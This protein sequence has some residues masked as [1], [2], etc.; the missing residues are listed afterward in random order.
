MSR[1]SCNTIRDILPLYVDEVVSA[2][3]REIVEEHLDDCEACRKWCA[4]MKSR[5]VI[6][7][8]SDTKPLK[9]FKHAWKRKRF[10]ISV[11]SVVLT[12]TVVLI[13]YLVYE[14]V[15]VVHD[16]F[17]PATLV[18]MRNTDSAGQWQRLEIGETGC[19]NFDSVFHAKRM[20]LDGNCDGPA[21]FRVRDQQGNIVLDVFTLQPG[22]GVQL[23]KLEKNTSYIV[24]IKTSA[25]YICVTFS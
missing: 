8:E 23:E 11:I 9:A 7:V 19:L 24:E 3:T 18:T 4:D 13:G 12:L 10:L 5:V 20:V 16:F 21:V 1:I 14:N 22:T 2:E 15:G 25:T 17:S 6:P